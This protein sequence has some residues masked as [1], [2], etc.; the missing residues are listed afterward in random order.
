MMLIRQPT[1]QET[2]E[3]VDGV[4]KAHGFFL[5][6]KLED[7]SAADRSKRDFFL[8]IADMLD[9]I[10]GWGLKVPTAD[11]FVNRYATG[12]PM[13]HEHGV[14]EIEQG[15]ISAC[16]LFG[17]ARLAQRIAA[18][19]TA[20]AAQNPGVKALVGWPGPLAA[21]KSSDLPRL[22]HEGMHCVQGSPKEDAPAVHQPVEYQGALAFIIAYLASRNS[23]VLDEGHACGAAYEV[24][25]EMGMGWPLPK[26]H[27][28]V[29]RPY[30][31]DQPHVDMLVGLL[32][33]LQATLGGGVSMYGISREMIAGLRDRG[34]VS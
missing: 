14:D 5:V 28:E 23:L 18:L 27:A 26:D 31:L 10:R 13:P 21:I 8:G 17:K 11:E 2:R 12:V 32:G 25:K 1:D 15:L 6:S 22:T 9:E 34:C 20:V 30:N 24:E 3:I 4:Y 29:F 33:T 7:E 19:L 16:A